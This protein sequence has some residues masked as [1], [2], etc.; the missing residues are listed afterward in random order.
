MTGRGIVL[1]ERASLRANVKLVPEQACD[2]ARART[3]SSSSLEVMVSFRVV[4][5]NDIRPWAGLGR[6]LLK[7]TWEVYDN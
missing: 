3:R 1:R 2:S 5:E 6:W 7:D 4:R